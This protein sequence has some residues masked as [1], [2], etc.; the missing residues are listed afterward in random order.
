MK[1]YYCE[2]FLSTEGGSVSD[3]EFGNTWL[4]FQHSTNQRYIS[5]KISL[6]G[7]VGTQQ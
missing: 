6:E 5:C 4:K 1:I 7:T 3:L 2:L